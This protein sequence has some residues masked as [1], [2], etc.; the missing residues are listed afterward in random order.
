MLLLSIIFTNNSDK[1]SLY[2]LATIKAA[3]QVNNDSTSLINPR[4]KPNKK[5]RVVITNIAVIKIVMPII[6][7]KIY[8]PLNLRVEKYATLN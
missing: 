3:T 8:P 4:H 5:D 7:H 1:V 6:L 2:N